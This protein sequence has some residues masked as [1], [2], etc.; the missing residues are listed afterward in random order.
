[1]KEL[2]ILAVVSFGFV[3]SFF[4][5]KI[6]SEEFNQY[7]KELIKAKFWLLV[8]LNLILLFLIVIRREIIL[9]IA[10]LLGL[11]AFKLNR[12]YI[13]LISAVLAVSQFSREVFLLSTIIYFQNVIEGSVW[14]KKQ[15]RFALSF[16]VVSAFVFLAI[17]LL[18]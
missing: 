4:L 9:I 10:L 3:I 13:F 17:Y 6:A 8:A 16:F 15:A 18:I 7:K 2:I 1:M 14:K 12:L 5:Y 11:L